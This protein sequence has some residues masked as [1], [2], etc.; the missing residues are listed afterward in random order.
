M[1]NLRLLNPSGM[2]VSIVTHLTVLTVGLAYAGVRPFETP[3]VDAIAV[4]LVTPAE[5]PLEPTP[6][7]EIPDFSATEQPA[8]A[9]KPAVPPPQPAQQAMPSAASTTPTTDAQRAAI[10]PAPAMAYSAAAPQPPA[11]WRPPEPDLSV[12]YQVNLGLPARRGDDF[13]AVAFT[14]AKVSTDDVAKFREHLKTCSVLPASIALNDKVTIRLRASFLPDGML[15]SAPL[16]IEA[17]ASA[18]GPLLMQAAIQALAACQPHAVLPA[19]KYNE[20]KVLDLD[21][22]PRDFKGG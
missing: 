13:D 5:V 21:F 7:L 2:A 1:P 16:L 19:D 10:P 6:P 11:S 17:S 3:P 20:W 18:K 12:K 8:A 15:A 22:T 4:D 14:A 9:S